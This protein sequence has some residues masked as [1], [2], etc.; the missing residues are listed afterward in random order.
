[1]DLLGRKLGMKKGMVFK[2][3]IDEMNHTIGLAKEIEVL[4]PLAETLEKTVLELGAT[5]MDLGMAAMSEKFE[6]AF[7]HASPFLE[8]TGD[9]VLAWMHLRR[10]F[11]AAQKLE[12]GDALKEKDRSFYTGIITCARFFVDTVLPVT[13]GK[14]TS[15]RGLSNAALDMEDKAY[16]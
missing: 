7:A 8:V 10:A 2:T 5:A 14:M 13:H 6:T 16:G 1:M 12:V 11:A 4:V 15:I 3:L 9:V